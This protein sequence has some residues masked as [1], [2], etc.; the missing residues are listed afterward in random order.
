VRRESFHSVAVLALAVTTLG[1]GC[2]PDIGKPPSL[3]EAPRILAVRQ[4]PPE[5]TPGTTASFEALVGDVSGTLA[6]T[7]AWT[8]CTTPKPPSESNSVS[9]ACVTEPDTGP[10]ALGAVSLTMPSNG[11]SLFGPDPPPVT[12]PVRPRDPDATGGFYIPVRAATLADDGNNL[13]AFAFE[14]VQCNLANAPGDVARTY[15]MTYVPNVAPSI[16]D[17]LLEP[18]GASPASVVGPGVAP[19]PAVATATATTLRVSWPAEASES[20]VLYDPSSRTLVS[21]REALRVSW[22]ASDGSFAHDRT[23]RTGLEPETST[24]NVW[25]APEVAVETVVHFWVVLRDE[26]GGADFAAFDLVVSP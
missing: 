20:Y 24:D 19:V 26:R 18:D 22:F 15:N 9:Q 12:P 23:G 4:T 10:G 17:V 25:T 13:L 21:P 2:K 1:P 8:I 16:A 5:V 7:V 6:A 11:C 3:V 14:R